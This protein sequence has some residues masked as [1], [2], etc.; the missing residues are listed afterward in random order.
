MIPMSRSGRVRL[1]ASASLAALALAGTG[2]SGRIMGDPAKPPPPAV[3]PPP[4]APASCAVTT[5]PRVRRLSQNELVNVL[6]DL[7]GEAV[8][9]YLPFAADPRAGGFDN[10]ADTLTVSGEMPE[11]FAA[12]AEQAA[13]ALPVE[14]AA[15]CGVG[16]QPGDC[17]RRFA[18]GFAARAYGRPLAGD[19]GE[20]LA[21][22]FAAAAGDDGYAAGIRL[23]VEAIL[24]SP[25]FIYRTEL[26]D[27]AAPPGGPVRLT[28]HEVA[29][30][31][32][33]L[34]TGSR[35]DPTLLAAA[36]DGSLA[37]AGER[38]RQARRLLALP[39]ARLHLR[40]FLIDWLGLD[41]LS[42]MTKS[43]DVF[44][45][46]FFTL[47]LRDEMKVEVDRF[48]DRALAAPTG[49]LHA[50]LSPA[51]SFV[52][53]GVARMIYR[54]DALEAPPLQGGWI[55][56]DPRR[57]RGV[58]TLPGFLAAHAGVT[59][60][61]PVDRGLF[62][63]RR[64]LCR[65]VPAPPP[66]VDVTPLPPGTATRTTRQALA[67]HTTHAACLPCHKH[68]DPLGLGFEQMDALG[69]FRTEEAGQPVDGQGALPD[70][71]DV[72]GPFT[73]PAELSAR[74]ERSA[75]L[76]RCFVTV[77][78]RWSEAR[79]EHPADACAVDDLRARW[80][81]AGPAVARLDDLLVE[82]VGSERFVVRAQGVGP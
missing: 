24:Q 22:L 70:D 51:D 8:P 17:A 26:G 44:P 45:P 32:S 14:T 79:E 23:M 82:L 54:E 27:P 25:H 9:F 6:R 52:T 48:L 57:R 63:L 40:R 77:T 69:R 39:R 38:R 59:Q 65:D 71:L 16:D 5:A 64:L 81:A 46:P 31:L 58:L 19:E 35:P 3:N 41:R 68:I 4:A 42:R 28:P 1:R 20:R 76:A 11:H 60:T 21:A 49:V 36:S 50:L 18:D 78:W 12:L 2:C 29:S 15:P 74:L 30:Q 37:S 80:T 61:S 62:V 43:Y 7:V 34:L 75:E 72:G 67:E 55:R 66:G 47:A 53:P 56:L 33:F 13:A 73:G 10:Q